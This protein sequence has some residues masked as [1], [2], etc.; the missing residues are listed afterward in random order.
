LSR[1]LT[2]LNLAPPGEPIWRAP[3]AID[4]PAATGEP[5][6]AA[7]APALV[8]GHDGRL[9]AF[10]S[11]SSLAEPAAGATLWHAVWQGGYWSR[12]LA[13]VTA[14]GQMAAQ[15]A[16]ALSANGRLVVLWSGG[17]SGAITFSWAAESPSDLASEWAEP[18]LLPAPGPVASSP[19]IVLDSETGILYA[20]YAVPLNEGRG[21]YLARSSDGGESWAEAGQPFDASDWDMVDRPRLSI[22]A[23]QLHLLFEKRSLPGT[24]AS[25]ELYYTR[26][27][28]GGAT[29]SEPEPVTNGASE[30]GVLLWADLFAAGDQSVHRLWRESYDGAANLWHQYSPDGGS[31]WSQAERIGRF[32]DRP[33][34]AALAF[35]AAGQLYLMV[36][37]SAPEGEGEKA[38]VEQWNWLTGGSRWEMAA[39]LELDGQA[40]EELVAAI[41][42]PAGDDLEGHLFVLFTGRSGSDRPTRLFASG[43]T[44]A[45]T[46][47]APLPAI[48]PAP[49]TRPPLLTPTAQP[50][51]AVASP[52]AFPR[53]ATGSGIG[54]GFLPQSGGGAIATAALLALAPS[55]VIV[56]LVI[57]LYSRRRPGRS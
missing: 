19:V 10:W 28:D 46:L 38:F 37:N 32:A 41:A 9:H 18:A 6:T 23:G 11:Q 4:E 21:I 14:A 52:V 43:R 13:L 22:A 27:A 3:E 54:L 31:T 1:G 45:L 36:A 51:A 57:T 49:A 56:L 39:T 30:R 25:A 53:E 7:L 50:E 48:Q 29:W 12:P 5:L 17:T 20:A 15:P 26:S 44:L 16:A 2:T 40:P 34:P 35:D 33:A 47:P 24:V 8:A 42:S 55:L